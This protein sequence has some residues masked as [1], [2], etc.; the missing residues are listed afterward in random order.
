M[1]NIYIGYHQSYPIM[2]LTTQNSLTSLKSK[3]RLRS[4]QSLV[5]TRGLFAYKHKT[6]K[7]WKHKEKYENGEE[8]DIF[9]TI[10]IECPK[11]KIS[12]CPPYGGITT[13]W[14]LKP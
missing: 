7:I 3:M 14:E 2:C 12:A 8:Y 1:H 6:T 5:F 9:G 10:K 11:L 13:P 4:L